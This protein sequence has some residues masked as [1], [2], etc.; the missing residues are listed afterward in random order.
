MLS[1]LDLHIIGSEHAVHP[2]QRA[3]YRVFIE[4]AILHA[5]HDEGAAVT[6]WMSLS[7]CMSTQS[8]PSG[9]SLGAG[10]CS[11]LTAGWRGLSHDLGNNHLPGSDITQVKY[12][13]LQLGT[14]RSAEILTQKFPFEHKIP[15]ITFRRL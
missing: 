10:H 13:S 4:T 14:L 15:S 7:T 2:P 12:I 8:P 6:Q 1:L 3:W 9:P 11:L 5:V